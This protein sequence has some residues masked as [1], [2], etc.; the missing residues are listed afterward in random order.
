MLHYRETEFRAQR[1]LGRKRLLAIIGLCRDSNPSGRARQFAAIRQPQG[2][3][4]KRPTAWWARGDSNLQPDRYGPAALTIGLRARS[5]GARGQRRAI[6]P[7]SMP[8]RRGNRAGRAMAFKGATYMQSALEGTWLMPNNLLKLRQ[9]FSK[10]CLNSLPC[11]EGLGV[12]VAVSGHT[13]CNN[14]YPPPQPSPNASRA[15]PT[16]AR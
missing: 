10:P 6:L 4:R 1:Q 13:S 3:L 11:G 15:C 5:R 14:R 9:L 8:T 12:G 16:C 7:S 2:N